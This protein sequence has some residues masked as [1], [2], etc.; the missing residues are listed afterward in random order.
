MVV[1][2]RDVAASGASLAPAPWLDHDDD[3]GE[4]D[5]LLGPRE[6]GTCAGKAAE[7]AVKSIAAKMEERLDEMEM[8]LAEKLVP[9]ALLSS[10]TTT[11]RTFGTGIRSWEGHDR[12]GALLHHLSAELRGQ[13]ARRRAETP[14]D[15][16]GPEEG[17]ALHI[18]TFVRAM[19][20]AM[21]NETTA[22]E[23]NAVLGSDH[24][25]E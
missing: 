20:Q 2:A 24:D 12:V 14:R 8:K 13:H 21:T 19:R 18:F 17:Q 9:A 15:E 3:G 23:L 7:K 10:T 1:V 16:F 4:S 25:S 22:D 5:G 11:T 6:V